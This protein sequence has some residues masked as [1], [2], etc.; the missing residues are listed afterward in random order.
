MIGQIKTYDINGKKYDIVKKGVSVAMELK[1][2]WLRILMQSGMD[3]DKNMSPDEY[4]QAQM[5]GMYGRIISDFKLIMLDIVAAP[6]LT[7]ESYE[8]MDTGLLM[9]LFNH[10]FDFYFAAADDKKKEQSEQ[11]AEDVKVPTLKI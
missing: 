7:P 6:K 5:A 4:I 1:S 11:S 3:I 10:A 9:T 8:E 2:V